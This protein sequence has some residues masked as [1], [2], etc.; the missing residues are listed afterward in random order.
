MSESVRFEE[1]G[2]SEE[3][4]EGLRGHENG[5]SRSEQPMSSPEEE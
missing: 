5:A 2:V 4:K 3:G 1:S